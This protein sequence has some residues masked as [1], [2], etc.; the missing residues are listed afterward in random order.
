MK[1]AVQEYAPALPEYS[2]TLIEQ[3][4]RSIRLR[5]S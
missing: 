5:Y 2:F 3:R 1:K 4:G